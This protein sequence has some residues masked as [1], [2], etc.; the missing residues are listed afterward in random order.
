MDTT[1]LEQ[2]YGNSERAKK[3]LGLSRQLWDYWAKNGIPEGRQYKIQVM[4]NGKLRA[5]GQNG[6]A[7]K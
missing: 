7:K 1:N 5:K 4:T 6:K 3:A 2:H